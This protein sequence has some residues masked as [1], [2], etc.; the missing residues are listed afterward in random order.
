MIAERLNLSV[1]EASAAGVPPFRQ[2]PPIVPIARVTR[3]QA[4]T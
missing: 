3:S 1:R 2:V 4:L